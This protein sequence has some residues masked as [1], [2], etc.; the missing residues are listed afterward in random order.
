M[1]CGERTAISPTSPVGRSLTSSP[2][3][4]AGKDAHGLLQQLRRNRRGAID[5]QAQA[6]QVGLADL[7][8]LHQ[9]QDH[10]GDQQH[11]LQPFALDDLQDLGRNEFAHD[12]VGGAGEQ[13]GDAPPRAADVEHRQADEVGHARRQ[14]PG[15]GPQGKHPGEVGVGEL[16]ALGQAGG[17]AGVE[18]DGG[19]A[20]P[21]GQ[22]RIGGGL[23]VAPFGEGRPG[24]VAAAEGH[25]LAHRLQLI[26]DLLDHGK[27]FFAHEQN[28]GLGIVQ[29]VQHFRR[30]ETPIDRDHHRVGLGSAEQQLEENIAALVE[31]GHARLRRDAFGDQ[32]VGHL[33]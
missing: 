26:A 11:H 6:R 13:A 32:P 10:G 30:G 3:E 24:A 9:E 17:A 1:I 2:L 23:P 16:G 33:V 19:V 22:M 8:R 14:Q 20:G 21:D 31:M 4:A 25:D 18:L 5:D 12:M 7:R 15:P 28:F 27:V 29:D